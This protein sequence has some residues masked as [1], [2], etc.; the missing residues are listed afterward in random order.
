[1][2][3]NQ[4]RLLHSQK[5]IIESNHI[6]AISQKS[7]ELAEKRLDRK[8]APDFFQRQMDYLRQKEVSLLFSEIYDFSH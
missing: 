1:V 2:K 3:L 5:D 4:L 8:A 7:V 6:P